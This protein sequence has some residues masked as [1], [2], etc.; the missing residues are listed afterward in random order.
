MR[1]AAYKFTS[2]IAQKSM[3][4]SAVAQCMHRTYRVRVPGVLDADAGAGLGRQRH[5]NNRTLQLITHL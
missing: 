3:R 4:I 1:R 2:M 5:H